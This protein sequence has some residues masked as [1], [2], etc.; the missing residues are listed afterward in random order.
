[1]FVCNKSFKVDHRK[2][3]IYLYMPDLFGFP[4]IVNKSVTIHDMPISSIVIYS[5]EF[6][7]PLVLQRLYPRYKKLIEFLT[8]ILLSDDDSGESYREALNQIERFLI[9]LQNS[10]RFFLKEKEFEQMAKQLSVLKKECMKRQMELNDYYMALESKR[11][12]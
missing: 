8:N 2:R 6:A 4:M 1:M 7:H 10:Y 3:K 12:K 9:I 5:V 11:S